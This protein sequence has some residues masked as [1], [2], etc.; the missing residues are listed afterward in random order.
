MPLDVNFLPTA[1]NC[2]VH[3]RNNGHVQRDVAFVMTRAPRRRYAPPT[4]TCSGPVWCVKVQESRSKNYCGRVLLALDRSGHQTHA[5]PR[6]AVI[7][8]HTSRV[9]VQNWFGQSENVRTTNLAHGFREIRSSTAITEDNHQRCTDRGNAGQYRI[10]LS[11]RKVTRMPSPAAS[12]SRALR[13]GCMVV[14]LHLP[15]FAYL[16]IVL[17]RRTAAR[18]HRGGRGVLRH[19]VGGFEAVLRVRLKRKRYEAFYKRGRPTAV[20]RPRPSADRADAT[21]TKTVTYYKALDGHY[22]CTGDNFIANHELFGSKIAASQPNDVRFVEAL[23][24]AA[25][26]PERAHV[27]RPRPECGARP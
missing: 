23:A 26:A 5:N 7:D 16:G 22:P 17:K 19:R 6:L 11:G 25:G 15:G 4:P 3:Q 12:E 2:G 20:P 10:D 21:V 8:E 27:A 1:D 18:T 9:S 24:P 13:G 14:H